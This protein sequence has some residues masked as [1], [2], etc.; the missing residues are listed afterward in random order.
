MNDD[1]LFICFKKL[2]ARELVI[3]SQVCRGWRDIAR[4]IKTE[5]EK[6]NGK[7][8]YY[9]ISSYG[10][11]Y[12]LNG[13]LF[14]ERC[15]YLDR[16]KKTLSLVNPHSCFDR[17]GN[18]FGFN[19]EGDYLYY[20]DDT[21]VEIKG[22]FIY[23]T[24]KLFLPY[25]VI[26]DRSNLIIIKNKKIIFDEDVEWIRNVFIHENNLILQSIY[27]DDVKIII[28]KNFSFEREIEGK[29][30]G[31][32]KDN[33]FYHYLNKPGEYS[34]FK[35]EELLFETDQ[36]IRTTILTDDKI[37]LKLERQIQ[38]VD[39][40]GTLVKAKG[41]RRRINQIYVSRNNN[42]FV[43]IDDSLFYYFHRWINF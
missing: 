7:I 21:R 2:T 23:S 42:F 22:E 14:V 11:T 24:V 9:S 43:Q 36:I 30:L 5:L 34:M 1:V 16:D 27:Y 28:Y 31:Y 37:F 32:D 39:F 18:L 26:F 19:Y 41:Y 3:V 29:F 8:I 15:L 12:Y 20:P 6:I 25:V 40:S 38:I 33:N 4:S 35:N 10:M 17:D 13:F